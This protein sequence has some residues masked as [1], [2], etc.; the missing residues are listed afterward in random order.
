MALN[1]P[2]L[3]TLF[4]QPLENEVFLLKREGIELEAT[5]LGCIATIL[6]FIRSTFTK[7]FSQGIAA[8]IL[9]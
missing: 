2:L 8:E 6:L 1:P 5:I 3:E 4:P 7:G 9:C